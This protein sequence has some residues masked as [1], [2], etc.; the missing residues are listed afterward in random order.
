MNVL[1]IDKLFK[2]ISV[3]IER[4][5]TIVSGTLFGI[6]TIDLKLASPSIG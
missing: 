2:N 1:N 6:V 5:V 4:G 3:R